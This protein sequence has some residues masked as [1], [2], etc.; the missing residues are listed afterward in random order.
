MPATEAPVIRPATAHDFD[1]VLA[2]NHASVALLSPLDHARLARLHAQAALHWVA[3]DAAGT[4]Q[5]FL[6][7]FGPGA[8]YDS[9]N[10]RWFAA[11]YEHFL[12]IDRVVVAATA[13]G[14]GLGERLYQQL[15]RTAQ[16]RGVPRLVCEFDADPPNPGSARFHARLGF[17]EV[18]AQQVDY[19][20]QGGGL[21]RVSMQSAAVT[22]VDA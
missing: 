9:P 22:P 3:A 14:Q 6:L 13:R 8:D 4:V 11:R 19:R 20:A 17:V 21:K 15:F 1:A 16:G 10:Y 2:L 12:Y 7:V 18:G 5:A